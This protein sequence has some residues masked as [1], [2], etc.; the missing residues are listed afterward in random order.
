M[1]ILYQ[2]DMISGS[3]IPCESRLK[4]PLRANSLSCVGKLARRHDMTA[5]LIGRF[6]MG[7]RRLRKRSR[8][9]IIGA[10]QYRY[11]SLET[12]GTGRTSLPR[13]TGMTACR[14]F[15]ERRLWY[16]RP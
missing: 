11:W 9:N 8:P 7:D 16:A 12:A 10:N 15:A 4:S 13:T 6:G 5:T 3:E 14:R 2:I 1:P